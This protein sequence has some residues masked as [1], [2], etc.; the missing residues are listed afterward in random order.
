MWGM[1]IDKY[2][3]IWDIVCTGVY[4]LYIYTYVH[5]HTDACDSVRV[6]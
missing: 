4:T 1:C 5:V 3:Y 2:I 6:T